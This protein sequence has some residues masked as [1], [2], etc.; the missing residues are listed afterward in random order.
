MA[1]VLTGQSGAFRRW[2]D[3][4]SA[5]H[6]QEDG[7]ERSF[8]VPKTPPDVATGRPV[9]RGPDDPPQ[10][11]AR[12]RLFAVL[13][14]A[15]GSPVTLVRAPA[16]WG[17]TVLLSA[18]ARTRHHMW[19]PPDGGSASLSERLCAVLCGRGARSLADARAALSHPVTVVVDDCDALND[20]EEIA[21][22]AGGPLRLVLAVRADRRLPL[23]HWR[24]R[25]ELG[26]LTADQL[27]FTTAETN[28]LLA[29]YGLAL[30]E[31]AVAEVHAVTEGWPAALRLAAL[32]MRGTAEPEEAIAD[33]GVLD[34]IAE[35]VNVEVLAPLPAE[36]RR[37]L[38]DVSV[39]EQ[40]TAEFV[41]AVTGRTDGG[42]VLADLPFLRPGAGHDSYRM[43]S[44]VSQLLA[45]EDWVRA[46][47]VLDRHW[48]DIVLGARRRAARVV[49]ASVPDPVH[50]D[51][52]LALA[53]AAERLDAGDLIGMRRFL[54]ISEAREPGPHPPDELTVAFRLADAAAAG[55][56]AHVLDLAPGLLTCAERGGRSLGLIATGTANLQLGDL[57]LAGQQ[58]RDALDTAR[59]AGLGKAQVVAGS[60]LAFWHASLGRLR[61]ADRLGREALAL[62][63]RLGLTHMFDL[64]WAHL[65]LAEAHYEWDRL[66]EA[67]A[68]IDEA[69]EGASGHPLVLIAAATLQ[70]KIELAAG[71]LAEAHDTLLTARQE[72]ACARVAP[73]VHRALALVEAELRLAGG[74]IVAARRRLAG[75][76]DDD[77]LPSWSAIV[78][79]SVLLAEGDPAAAAA[80]VAPHLTGA[81]TVPLTRTVQAG[82]LTALAGRELGDKDRITRGLDV[83]LDAAEEEGFRRPFAAYGSAMRELIGDAPPAT[84]MYRPV[85]GELSRLFELVTRVPCCDGSCRAGRGGVLVEPLTERE[86][87][88]LRYLQGTLSNV[89]IAELL[90][91]S[92]NTVKTHLR[93]IYRKLEAGSRRDAVRRARDLL[94]L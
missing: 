52:R 70:S 32:T 59:A 82:I 26:E 43:H 60:H 55:D 3:A 51:A 74:D 50:T 40:L 33:L 13:D 42:Q 73:P 2:R 38:L 19:L 83:A 66:S 80:V 10:H 7:R 64:G 14:A 63:E 45:A 28:Q 41:Q 31:S 22:L 88:V 76:H 84:V 69:L 65:A 36:L 9:F 87:V 53:F 39:G 29:G 89:E 5:P 35:Y 56:L 91:L 77:P 8:R 93:S 4:R 44:L 11:L 48:P 67:Q 71:Q 81:E 16:G 6:R 72:A 78:E 24:L 49:S 57:S 20:P 12:P 25:G 68:R 54:R 37:L 94:L 79:G 46:V 30:P 86:L 85:I 34:L 15:S 58:L 1:H 23:R 62:A 75:W 47:D 18:W 17:K 92:V 61:A 21:A 90:H 27:A